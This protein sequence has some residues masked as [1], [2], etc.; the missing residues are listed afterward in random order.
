[1][2]SRGTPASSGRPL[3]TTSLGSAAPTRPA[4]ARLAVRGRVALV[5]LGGASLLSGLNA[6]LVRLELWAPVSD[7]RLGDVHGQVMVL[8]FLGT[9]ISLERAQALG[10]AWAFLAPALL[11]AG[12][13]ALVSPAPPLLGQLLQVEGAA[14]FVATYEAL[15]RRAP[16]PL[17]A[18]QALSGV[19]ALGGAVVVLAVFCGLPVIIFTLAR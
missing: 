13:L 10:R 8:G 4:P 3:V 19:L 17:V 16:R 6:A 2:V 1:M 5:A 15:W 12:A 7:S 9:L 11:G 18:V 14:L